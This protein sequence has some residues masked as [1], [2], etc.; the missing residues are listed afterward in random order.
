MTTFQ[1]RVIESIDKM[2]WLDVIELVKKY[3]AVEDLDTYLNYVSK[4]P[5]L[6]HLISAAICLGLSTTYHLFFVYSPEAC[7]ML[8]KLDYTGITI[9]FFGSTVPFIQYMFA[10]NEVACKFTNL[11]LI[12]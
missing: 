6:V 7:L 3:R 12:F 5:L 9:L 11:N 8:A 4:W 2:E 1:T 10:C